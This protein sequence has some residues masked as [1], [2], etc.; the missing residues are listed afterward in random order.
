MAS[1]FIESIHTSFDKQFP[2]TRVEQLM[3]RSDREDIDN[4]DLKK[5]E[6]ELFGLTKD[7]SKVE[8]LLVL[9]KQSIPV[10]I[11]FFLQVGATFIN[12]VFASQYKEGHGSKSTVFTGISL[13]NMFANVSCL[14]ILIGMTGAIETLASQNNGAGNFREVGF[15]LQRSC[16]ILGLIMLPVIILWFFAADIFLSLGF[17]RDVCSIIQGYMRIRSLAIPMDI[18]NESYEKYLTAIGV[19]EPPMWANIA[20]NVLVLLLNLLFVLVL[21][22]DY[23]C[24]AWSWVIALYASAALQIALSWNHPSVRKTLQPLDR[25][26][27]CK[28]KEFFALGFPG[29]V[30]LCSEW[31]AYEILTV[32]ASH[33]GTVQVAAQSIILQTAS[34]VFMAPLGVGVACASLVGNSLGAKRHKLATQIGKVSVFAIVVL[35][36]VMSVCV[37]FLGQYFV[38]VF[39]EDKRVEAS[40]NKSLPFLSAFII[41]DGIQ[42]VASGVLRGAG[43]QTVGAVANV[44]AFYG[45]GLPAAWLFCFTC[46]FGVNGLLLGIGVGTSFQVAVL[47]VLLTRYE[48]YVFSI[49]STTATSSPGGDA[50]SEPI[51]P[52]TYYVPYIAPGSVRTDTAENSSDENE[53]KFHMKDNTIGLATLG[54]RTMSVAKTH[55]SNAMRRIVMGGMIPGGDNDTAARGGHM[56]LSTSDE[57]NAED[58][59][60][61]PTFAPWKDEMAVR[62]VVD[63]SNNLSSRSPDENREGYV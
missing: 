5:H 51:A 39:S 49:T 62:H 46:G 23:E 24:L 22:F 4:E 34:L 63:G 44:V 38:E 37:L 19:M 36:T 21:K 50:M 56:P 28:W 29:T 6:S 13:A 40:A 31:Y 35:E 1:S 58:S 61:S 26:A 60:D 14:S 3:K 9:T 18:I 41:I 53:D 48:N 59:G 27:F 57:D 25:Q 7:S 8:C 17:D 52:S 32:F 2:K 11:A 12:L 16:A 43:K 20:F 10:I 54:S 33:L 45:I 42:G 15:I 30:M 47:L 55:V